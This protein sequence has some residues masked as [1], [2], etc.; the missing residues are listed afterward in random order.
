MVRIWTEAARRRDQP[1]ARN[2]A[3]RYLDEKRVEIVERRAIWS[4]RR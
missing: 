3:V 4:D 1:Y 2:N